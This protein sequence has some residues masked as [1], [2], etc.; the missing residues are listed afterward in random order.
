[1]FDTTRFLAENFDDTDGVLGLLAKHDLPMPNREAVRKWFSRAS[2]T[3]DW[4][5]VLLVALKRE[6][7]QLADVEPYLEQENHDIFG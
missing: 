6:T 7:G 2:V 3:G 5:A 1:M 4:L